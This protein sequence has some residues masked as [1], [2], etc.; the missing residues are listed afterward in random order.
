VGNV[1]AKRQ[2]QHADDQLGTNTDNDAEK[3]NWAKTQAKGAL[4][5]PSKLPSNDRSAEKT[6]P[7]S[8][9]TTNDVP[10]RW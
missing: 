3:V 6:D 8:D 1:R 7:Q 4:D 10:R 5:T 9:Q 2:I